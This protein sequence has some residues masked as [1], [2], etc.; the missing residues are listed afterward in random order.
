MSKTLSAESRVVD[1]VSNLSHSLALHLQT[2]ELLCQASPVVQTASLRQSA[3]LQLLRPT[4]NNVPSV[5]SNALVFCLFLCF[6]HRSQNKRIYCRKFTIIAILFFTIYNLHMKVIM[7]TITSL[8][9]VKS[10]V[11]GPCILKTVFA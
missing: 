3:Q 6:Q 7:Y 10:I 9:F 2:V 5:V 11:W 8:S 1:M 4:T